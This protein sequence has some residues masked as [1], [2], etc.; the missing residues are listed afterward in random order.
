MEIPYANIDQDGWI[1]EELEELSRTI[2][3]RASYLGGI[4]PMFA[5]SVAAPIQNGLTLK[6]GL[7]DD[8]SSFYFDTAANSITY[9]VKQLHMILA[10]AD[11]YSLR[12]GLDDEQGARL[13]R[14]VLTLFVL[15][16]LHHV[17]QGVSRFSD[18]QKIREISGPRVIARMDLLADRVALH[19]MAMLDAG[20]ASNPIDFFRAYRL[21]FERGLDINGEIFFRAF[22]FSPSKPEKNRRALGLTLMRARFALFERGFDFV[23]P[24]VEMPALDAAI[25]PMADESSSALLLFSFDPIEKLIG[26]VNIA[27]PSRLAMLCQSIGHVDFSVAVQNAIDILGDAGF[28]GER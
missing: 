12:R 11:E 17:L 5:N 15:H 13:R 1:E 28:I 14:S 6:I 3:T 23:V 26:I 19:S 21:G 22:D 4:S 10:L 2:L 27:D 24:G 20:L 7:L 18:V 16:E 9:S 25:W 8:D